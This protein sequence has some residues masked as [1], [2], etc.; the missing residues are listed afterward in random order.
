M[1]QHCVIPTV[2]ANDE[3]TQVVL[4]LARLSVFWVQC[5]FLRK[6]MTSSRCTRGY[7]V[8][9]PFQLEHCRWVDILHNPALAFTKSYLKILING[10]VR[11]SKQGEPEDMRIL[12]RGNGPKPRSTSNGDLHLSPLSLC[13][14]NYARDSHESCC[15]CRSV[16]KSG[17][18]DSNGPRN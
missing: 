16:A 13:G 4:V 3:T 7:S 14:F 5:I 9:G 6:S 2:M 15:Y 12:W 1:C 11:S 18:S 8:L 17:F 10:I